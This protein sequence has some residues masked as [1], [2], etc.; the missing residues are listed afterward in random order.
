MRSSNNGRS[1]IRMSKLVIGW[2]CQLD[3]HNI[4]PLAH[5]LAL[6]WPTFIWVCM[7]K[8]RGSPTCV[9]TYDGMVAPLWCTIMWNPIPNAS[10]FLKIKFTHAT[11]VPRDFDP[12]ANLLTKS[13]RSCEHI[14]YLNIDAQDTVTEMCQCNIQRTFWWLQISYLRNLR[15]RIIQKLLRQFESDF[16]IV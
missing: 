10:H 15:L 7:C 13:K 6:E 2:Q 12:F 14:L 11:H 9:S 8:F 3:T 4:D 16:F 5:N 1:H